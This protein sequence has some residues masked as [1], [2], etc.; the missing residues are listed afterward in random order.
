MKHQPVQRRGV[1]QA[2]GHL[3]EAEH[4]ELG[5]VARALPRGLLLLQQALVPHRELCRQPRLPQLGSDA[6]GGGQRGAAGAQQRPS[7]ET[8]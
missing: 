1:D 5:E 3:I 6:R 8:L 4:S 7:G 2:G